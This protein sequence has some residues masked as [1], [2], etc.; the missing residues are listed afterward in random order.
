MLKKLDQKLFL[1]IYNFTVERELLASTA[2]F[3]TKIS[4]KFFS[5]IYFTAAGWL[6]YN[7]DSRLKAFILIPAAVYLAAKIIPQIYNR[8]RPFAVLDIKNLIEQRSDHSFP[9][10]HSSSSFIIALAV[11]KL[12]LLAG[13][14]LILAAIFTAISRIAVGVH[15]PGDVLGGICL[16]VVVNFSAVIFFQI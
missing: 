8:S 15:Y 10:T 1:K 13:I 9:S 12:N 2:V 16:A 6:I 11:L 5:I 3:I 7:N 4:S 14:I